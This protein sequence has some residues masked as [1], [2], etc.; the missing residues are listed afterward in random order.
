[1]NIPGTGLQSV[2]FKK[3]PPFGA[4]GGIPFLPGM[5]IIVHLARETKTEQT[6]PGSLLLVVYLNQRLSAGSGIH[7]IY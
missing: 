2:P 5:G 1:M 7:D 4:I 6:L 3:I